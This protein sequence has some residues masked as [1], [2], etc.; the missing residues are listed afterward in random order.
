MNDPRSKTSQEVL[1][2]NELLW[3]VNDLVITLPNRT[4][5]IVFP[6]PKKSF[7]E[8]QRLVEQSKAVQTPTISTLNDKIAIDISQF[9][10]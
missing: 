4:K 2:K 8:K 10:K 9:S 6:E 3:G 1:D 5:M 7:E